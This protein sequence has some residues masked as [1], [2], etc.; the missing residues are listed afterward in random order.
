MKRLW[1]PFAY[2]DGPRADCAWALDRD[3]PVLDSEAETD[4]AIVGGG[5][6]GLSAALHLAGA[7]E[8]V[9]VLEAHAPG[10]GASGRNGGFCCLGGAMASDETLT[11]RFGADQAGL[12]VEA[13]KAAIHL[14]AGLLAQ[15]GIDAKTHSHGELVLAHSPR[16]WRGFAADRSR[17]TR[18]GIETELLPS[19]ALAERGLKASSMQ[20]G[21][22]VKIGFGLDPGAYA[23]GLARAARAAGADIRG[24]S[25]VRR[26]TRE[27]GTYRL[28][29][30]QGS[31]RARR[32]LF[33]T[34]G[35]S[36]EDLPRWLAGR[37]MPLQS[38]VMVTRPLTEAERAAQGWTSDLM[39]YDSRRLLHYFRLMPDGRFLFGMRGGLKAHPAREA[40]VMARM[41]ADFEAMFPAWAGVETAH[42]W[43]G[44]VNLSRGQTPYLG[45]VPEMENAWT[46]MAYH[47]NGVAMASYS[48]AIMADLIRG[49][50][51]DR[52]FPTVMQAPL[53]RFPLGRRRRVLLA[54]MTPLLALG[55]RL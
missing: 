47:G 5:Y 34:N 28:T 43:S 51:P 25:E 23:I 20:G 19:A 11:R 13:E 2:S 22:H 26:I 1:E 42:S 8:Q 21:M 44:L 55:D 45:P 48:G 41:R 14:V 18:H 38:S 9:M 12:W 49:R 17:Y 15:H 24:Q 52:P 30:P 7:G 16:A 29:T 27:G 46:A 6:T 40:R 10:W 36:A 37:F 53:A 39:A 33:A 3:W 32:L 35:Y 4:I 50:A 31:L 54:A